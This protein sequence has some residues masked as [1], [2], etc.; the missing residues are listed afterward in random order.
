MF[1][2]TWSAH[3]ILLDLM[4]HAIFCEEYKLRSLHCAMFATVLLLPLSL[5]PKCHPEHSSKILSPYDFPFESFNRLDGYGI[6]PQRPSFIPR[7]VH[8]GYVTDTPVPLSPHH[9]IRPM[10][11]THSS[12]TQEMVNYSPSAQQRHI[13]PYPRECKKTNFLK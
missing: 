6:S 7:T 1:R 13:L 11:D 4:I 8:V 9:H 12:F 10:S 3:L 2:A 5:R